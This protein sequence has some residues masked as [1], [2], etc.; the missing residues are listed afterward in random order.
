M[1]IMATGG[2][3]R[4]SSLLFRAYLTRVKSAMSALSNHFPEINDKVV[5][6]LADPFYGE[7]NARIKSLGGEAG[8]ASYLG[9]EWNEEI[10]SA[11]A[12][13]QTELAKVSPGRTIIQQQPRV[14]FKMKPEWLD[15]KYN[16]F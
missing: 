4:D 5:K 2:Q 13:A 3:V 12:R 7:Y 9:G 16:P 11:V 1:Q 14:S 6:A 10:T 8:L 15:R